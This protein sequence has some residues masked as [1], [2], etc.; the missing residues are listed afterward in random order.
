MKDIAKKGLGTRSIHGG[1]MKPNAFG[2]LA[3][4]IFQTST[5][6]FGTAEQAR[7][8]FALEEAGYVYSRAGN[9]TLTVAE[10]K[11]A[12]LEQGEAALATSS[13]MGAIS[14]VLWTFLSAGDHVISDKT[15]YGCTFELL[16]HH[17][18][19][20]GVEV[21][22]VDSADP[23]AVKNALRPET[24][25]IYLESPANPNL[26]VVDLAEIAR[27]GHENGNTLT[28]V[29]NTFA[30]PYAQ[31]PLTLGCDIVVH[32]ATKYINGHGDLLAG[33]V[34]GKKELVDQVRVIGLKDMTGAVL[35]PMEAYLIIRG[36]KTFEIRME[37]ICATAMKVAEYLS[38]HPKVDVVHYPGLPSH[39]GYA[40]AK[41]QMRSFGP[42]MGF[43]LKG[44]LEAGKKLLDSVELCAL[45]VSL[46]DA[47]TLIQHPASMTHATYTP[48]ERKAADI[49]EGLIRLSVGLENA[50]DIIADLEQALSK[51]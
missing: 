40:I 51:V 41:K 15:L 10:E 22:F 39:P 47:E 17:M 26:K 36:L 48:E 14:S 30:T 9:P 2:A 25:I 28:V 46:G 12:L 24:R 16:N 7:R 43:E 6:T 35:P 20:F 49:A 38:R 4:P 42:M 33:F 32:S 29:D 37:R 5:F 18:K 3:T 19:R 1:Q 44:G 8:C 31:T 23:E 21:S 13:G 50:E 45:A 34:V 11:I 27:L